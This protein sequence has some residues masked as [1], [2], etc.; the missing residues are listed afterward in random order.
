MSQ[1]TTLSGSGTGLLVLFRAATCLEEYTEVGCTA[2]NGREDHL[3]E[4]QLPL[5][6]PVFLV[7]SGLCFPIRRKESLLRRRW[8]LTFLASRDVGLSASLL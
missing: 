4:S 2:G 5:C 6:D 1:H 7:C 8:H 3:A